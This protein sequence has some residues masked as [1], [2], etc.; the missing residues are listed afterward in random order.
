MNGKEFYEMSTTIQLMTADEL[1]MLPDDG[2]RYELVKG[3]IR[4]MSPTGYEHG[5]IVVNLTLPLA[6]H[7]KA[8]N[9]GV[10]CGAETGFTITQNPDTVRAPEIA[11]VRCERTPQTSLTKSYMV[12]APDLAVEVLSPSDTVYKVDEKVEE[13]LSAGVQ[14]VWVVNPRRRTITVYRSSNDVK[15]LT[16]NDAL[17]GQDVVQGFR[18]RVAEIFD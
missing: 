9:L 16:E 11:F 4:K 7:V 6:Q 15:T 5:V 3:E 8:N 2:F 17:D 13:W 1:F 12:G 18:C 10:V 14:A